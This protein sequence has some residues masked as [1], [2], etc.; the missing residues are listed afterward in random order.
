MRSDS[1]VSP[2]GRRG[3]IFFRAAYFVAF[4]RLALDEAPGSASSGREDSCARSR[5]L[6]GELCLRCCA[7][8]RAPRDR[9]VGGGAHR[10]VA[11][12]APGGV[13]PPCRHLAPRDGVACQVRA[14]FTESDG[15]LCVFCDM[16]NRLVGG[17]VGDWGYFLLFT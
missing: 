6:R 1:V 14:K 9:T 7:R 2:D 17:V 15:V 13:A 8:S 16:T 3:K 5:A 4:R 12:G 11:Q 10:S